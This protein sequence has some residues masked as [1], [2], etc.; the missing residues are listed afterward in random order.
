MEIV[1]RALGHPARRALLDLL[2]RRDGRTLSELDAHLEMTRFGTMKHLRILEAA[3][4]IATRRVGR[5]KRHYLNP[6]PIRLI[7]DRWISKYSEPWAS[8]LGELKRLEGPAMSDLKHVYEAFIRATPE[9]IWEAITDA[10]LT[11][12]YFYGTQVK[13]DWKVG[14]PIVYDYP[15]GRLAAEGR[16]L[17]ID[18]PRRLVHTFSAA[19]DEEVTPDAA[20]TVVWT[21]EPKGEACRV[22]CEHY[23]FT[24][25]TATWRSI[26]GGLSLILNGM[27]TLLE[28][29]EPLTIRR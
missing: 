11:R 18:P 5:E 24:G 26:T 2:R 15:D 6:V 19:W 25:D 4:L 12:R 20:H 21:I 8:A 22:V 13:S 10:S 23:G 9:R 17:E 28:T 16:I 29:G 3:G 27:K 7:H 14:S 1:F